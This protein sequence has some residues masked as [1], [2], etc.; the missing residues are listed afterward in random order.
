MIFK[1]LLA[2][3][4]ASLLL[5]PVVGFS[6]S[7]QSKPL[8]LEECVQIA[9]QKIPVISMPSDRH[10]S[11]KRRSLRREAAFTYSELLVFERSIP[12]GNQHV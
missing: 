7:G 8:T 3:A 9:L 10:A 4:L 6:Q 11:Q 12:P 5:F 1:K 2:F